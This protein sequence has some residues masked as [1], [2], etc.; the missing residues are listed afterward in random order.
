[1]KIT[2]DPIADAVYVRL[3]DHKGANVGQT[4][5]NDFG[6][7]IDTDAAGNPRGFEFLNVSSRGLPLDGLPGSAAEALKKFVSSGALEASEAI[8][9]EYE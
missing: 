1:M 2:F 7:I 4:T 5:V 3:F 6:V 9:R 8:E